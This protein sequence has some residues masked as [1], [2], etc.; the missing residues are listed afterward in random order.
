MCD[1]IQ[2]LVVDNTNK[3]YV[4]LPVN[5]NTMTEVR[6]YDSEGVYLG[7]SIAQIAYAHMEGDGGGK[8]SCENTVQA[9]SDLLY[10]QKIDGYIAMNMDGI[11]ILNHL[12]GGVTVTIEEDMTNID[13]AFIEGETIT[14][15]DDQAL[16]FVRA[17][18][19]VGDGTNESRMRRQDA[20][21]DSLKDKM[22]GKLK[23]N[24]KYAIDVYDQLS[25]SMITD[26]SDKEF[27]R[28]VNALTECDSEG[29]RDIEGTVGVDEFGFSTFEPD[30]DSLADTVIDLFYRRMEE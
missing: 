16:K 29:K 1:V 24:E 17:R 26:L 11:G 20:F 30:K 18:M 14:L 13:P 3:T 2:L 23:N 6:S 10:G 8:L 12:A 21:I 9:V 27:S 15:T 22:T 19:S 25:G 7:T 4:Q 28:I 5:R